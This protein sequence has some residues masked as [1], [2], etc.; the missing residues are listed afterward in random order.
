MRGQSPS[1]YG[2]PPA[3]SEVMRKYKHIYVIDMAG[4]VYKDTLGNFLG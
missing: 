3:V 2:L 4:K 1:I